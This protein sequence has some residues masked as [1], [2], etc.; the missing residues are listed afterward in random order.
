MTISR[1]QF[2]ARELRTLY[3]LGAIGDRSDRQLLEQFNTGGPEAAELA[4]AAL[5]ERH[6]PM[7]L[8]VCRS[9]L[10]NP[11]DA[12]DVFQATFLVLLRKAHALWIRDSLGPW[13][14]RVARRLAVRVQVA[15]RRRRALERRLADSKA[16]PIPEVAGRDPLPAS[17]L[18]H[19]EIDRLPGAATA[20]PS[21]FV[22]W[23]GKVTTGWP[24]PS[25]CPS[26]P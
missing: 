8:G 17:L 23:R 1:Q 6:G 24:E 26:E 3:Q 5:V 22:T 11:H 13:L 4:F 20:F 25:G 7:V 10:Q 18:L 19:E 9:L 2:A 21:S 14:F 15:S 16:P 12:Q